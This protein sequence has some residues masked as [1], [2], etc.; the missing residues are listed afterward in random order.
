EQLKSVSDVAG[1]GWFVGANGEATGANV[2]PNGKVDFSNDDDNVV[3]TRTGTDLAFNLNKDVNL[4][5]TGSLTA[6]GT[7]VDSNGLSFVDAA[8]NPI[9][10][11][12]QVGPNTITVAGNTGTPQ[13]ILL[14]GNTGTISGL[15]NQSIDYPEFADG[16]GRSASEE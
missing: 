6:G 16:T 13:A 4:G 12:T 11:T 14:D 8:G 1:S 3:I 9:A 15:S 7:R 5:A 2:A 10:N